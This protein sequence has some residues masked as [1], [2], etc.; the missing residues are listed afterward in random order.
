LFPEFVSSEEPP[1]DEEAADAA[2]EDEE[3]GKDDDDGE[4]GSMCQNQ[5][6]MLHMITNFS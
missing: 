1:E 3:H 6:S 5:G 4:L 2:A